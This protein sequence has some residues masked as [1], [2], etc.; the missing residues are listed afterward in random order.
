MIK[1]IEISHIPAD[2][3][4]VNQCYFGKEGSHHKNFGFSVY[5][6]IGSPTY[7]EKALH[8]PR[9]VKNVHFFC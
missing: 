3:Y 4:F 7:Q 8:K 9:K 1:S 5:W 2:F 6:V